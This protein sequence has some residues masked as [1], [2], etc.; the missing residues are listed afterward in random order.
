MREERVREEMGEETTG[1][2]KRRE[3]E[4]DG[5]RRCRRLHG[6]KRTKA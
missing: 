5:R 4:G 3:E 1:G 2:K 6:N